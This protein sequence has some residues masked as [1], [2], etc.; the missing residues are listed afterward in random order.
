MTTEKVQIKPCL[1]SVGAFGLVLIKRT[2]LASKIFK[3]ST[4]ALIELDRATIELKR[5]C[6]KIS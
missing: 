5:I 2:V 6:Q 3:F 1:L 4:I